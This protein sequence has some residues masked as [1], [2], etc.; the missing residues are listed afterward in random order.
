MLTQYL[1][2]HYSI[3]IT[4]GQGRYAPV[5]RRLRR[6]LYIVAKR[7]IPAI[8]TR[9]FA[10]IALRKRYGIPATLSPQLNDTN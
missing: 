4:I 2:R 8:R 9:Y 1:H 3:V 6:T 7:A 10:L 5:Y